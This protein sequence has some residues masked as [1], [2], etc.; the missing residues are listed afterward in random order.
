MVNQSNWK[1]DLCRLFKD[2]MNAATDE[3]WE[4]IETRAN[5]LRI[6]ARV[7]SRTVHRP[8][9]NEWSN[10]DAARKGAES[11]TG[12]PPGFLEMIELT[13][14]V[15][16]ELVFRPTAPDWE[17]LFKVCHNLEVLVKKNVQEHL[18]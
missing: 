16:E 7:A 4:R 14:T 3:N 1:W 9:T 18:N 5:D 11:Q 17:R 6:L 13:K 2:V 12:F 15:T 8:D 10:S